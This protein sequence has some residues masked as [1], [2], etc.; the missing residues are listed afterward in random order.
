MRRCVPSC[1]R[2][3]TG[4]RELPADAC[5]HCGSISI[6]RNGK[7]VK[8]NQRWYCKDCKRTFT[9]NVG[10]VLGM[11]KLPVETW[12]T[13][14]EAF[15][16]QLSLRNC[17]D[18]CGVGLRAAWF[19]RRRI[20]ECIQRYNPSF[21]AVAGD[22]VE[23]DETYFRDSYKGYRKGTMP[24]PARKSG[25]KAAKRG[26]SKQQVCVV[27]GIDDTGASFLVVSGRG[28]PGKERA[29]KALNGRIGKGALVVTDKSRG[30]PRRPRPARR[31]IGAHG[32]DRA[33]HQSH[34]QPARPSQGLHARFQGRVHEAPP[35]LPRMVPVD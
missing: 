22:R 17:T 33:R 4:S 3:C 24:R 14:V 13:Y 1:T 15:I 34:Q 7:T 26:L 29:Y 6:K 21:N 5:P 8:G 10:R 31:D 2:T 9:A 25:K 18:K 11:S 19:M 23:I 27:T 16:D 20:I 35:V 28:M 32:R 30:L 12:M